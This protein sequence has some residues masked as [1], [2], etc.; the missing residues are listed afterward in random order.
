MISD[1]HNGREGGKLS[2]QVIFG[3]IYIKA[4]VRESGHQEVL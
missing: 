2:T 3:E 4:V 1:A